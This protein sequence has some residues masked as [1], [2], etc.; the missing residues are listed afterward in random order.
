[1]SC[2][3]TSC[4]NAAGVRLCVCEQLLVALVRELPVDLERRDLAD[5]LGELGI[6]H[7]EAVV[8]R[9]FLQQALIDQLLQNGVAHLGIVEHGR[10][11]VGSDRLPHALLLLAH[12]LGELLL[13]D[14]LSGNVATS[15][16]R[17][18]LRK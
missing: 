17:P 1:M 5:E 9:L 2:A 8:P 15:C 11:E 12:R 16:A 7:A 6:G 4:S 3:R 10:I 18:V 14:G 13:R